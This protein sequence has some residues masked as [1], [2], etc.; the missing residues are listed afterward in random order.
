MI[1]RAAPSVRDYGRSAG[2]DD[3]FAE[4]RR[5]GRIWRVGGQL[6]EFIA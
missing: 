4:T 1:E 6:R 3:D 2:G 5:G